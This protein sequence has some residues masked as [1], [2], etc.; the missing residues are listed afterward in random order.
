[1]IYAHPPMVLANGSSVAVCFE[2]GDR[3]ISLALDNSCSSDRAKK[4]SR[5]S[6][7]L[8]EG[9]DDAQTEVTKQVFS[10]L[11]HEDDSSSEFLE[12]WA[13][14]ENFNRAMEWLRG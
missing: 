12:V 11:A 4:L 8:F 13:S 3:L 5:G 1:M 7:A 14:M 9:S 6:I 2:E 10:D